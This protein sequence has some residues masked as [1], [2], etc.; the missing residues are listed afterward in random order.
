MRHRLIGL[1]IMN[2]HS[3]VDAQQGAPLYSRMR[4]HLF[5]RSA[6]G[7][8]F[9][10]KGKSTT[11]GGPGAA[12]SLSH[13]FPPH[14]FQFYLAAA[15]LIADFASLVSCWSVCFSSSKVIWRSFAP[16]WSLSNSAYVRAVP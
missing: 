9:E 15:A 13:P 12:G 11:M 8:S 14:C 6:A 5:S 2:D 1:S 7:Q 16:S 4:L 3:D 10:R